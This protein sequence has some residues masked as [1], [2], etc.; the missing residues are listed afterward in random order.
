M[1]DQ[2]I[3][4]SIREINL[5][6]DI[7]LLEK[8]NLIKDF[9]KS[10]TQ[11]ICSTNEINNTK[12]KPE[13]QHY[14]HKLCNNFSFRCCDIIVDCLRCH[15]D[16]V[17]TAHKPELLNIQCKMCNEEQPSSN[18]CIK[19]STTFSSNYC[20]KCNIWTEK[21]IKHCDDCGLCRVTL[22]GNLYHCNKC[23]ICYETRNHDCVILDYKN[24]ICLYCLESLYDSQDKFCVLNCNH[25]V[26][27]S[28]MTDA[29]MNGNYK[30]PRCMESICEMD[31]T[32]LK[33]LIEYQSLDNEDISI[34]SLVYSKVFGNSLFMINEI[35]YK[36]DTTLYRGYFID[37]K[38]KNGKHVH[39]CLNQ[40][41]VIK[42]VKKVLIYCNDCKKR[43]ETLFHYLGNEC[44]DCN[45]F[46]TVIL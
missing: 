6:E 1:D 38:M 37:L 24:E 8:Q 41:D 32:L 39:G 33:S 10:I 23:N 27:K 31:W 21:N 46:N 36:N 30:C 25:I 26:H 4:K 9:M 3:L 12:T 28:C 5:R 22:N 11:K 40:N 34:N 18:S 35:D 2:Y 15:N 7:T 16:I 13:C 42:K 45:G 14:S 19:C 43:C 20:N 29:L 44:I 17:S